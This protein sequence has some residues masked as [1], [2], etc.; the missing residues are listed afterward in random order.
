MKLYK[1]GFIIAEMK[2]NENCYYDAW[3]LQKFSNDPIA[4]ELTDEA[5]NKWFTKYDM[6]EIVPDL[7]YIK[8]YKEYCDNLNLNT[9][10]L[11]IESPNKYPNIEEDI[12]IEEV[13]GYD[14]MGTIYYS[15]LYTDFK[16]YEQ[17][18]KKDNIILNKN[19]LFNRFEDVLNFIKLRKLDFNSGL[20]IENFWEETPVKISIV[21]ILRNDIMYFLF[22]LKEKYNNQ[23]VYNIVYDT[24]ELVRVNEKII[25]MEN[26]LD[27]LYESEIKL[28][29]E[30]L[31]MLK[32][33]LDNKIFIKSKILNE[34]QKECDA[35]L[36]SQ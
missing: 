36:N 31:K 30:L 1:N 29:D 14:C 34:W 8:K 26:L 4:K 12:E 10:V 27:N 2:K 3:P 5:D 11:L 32:E 7:K 24:E 17:E 20:N 21:N 9:K 19:G 16:N 6:Q 35:N 28:D 23:T 15:Y 33:I 18:L 22:R 25:A 13:M